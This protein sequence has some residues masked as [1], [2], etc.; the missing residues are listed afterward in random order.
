MRLGKHL[1]RHHVVVDRSVHVLHAHNKNVARLCAHIHR[2]LRTESGVQGGR[3]TGEPRPSLVHDQRHPALARTSAWL[4]A[5]MRNV[6]DAYRPAVSPACSSA[7]G[8]C[9]MRH[10]VTPGCI[11]A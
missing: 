3:P 1:H 5:D 2:R 11:V 6:P 10:E 8:M 4:Y 7:A 9:Y